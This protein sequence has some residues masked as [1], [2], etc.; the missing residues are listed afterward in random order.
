MRNL[1][2]KKFRTSLR[3]WVEDEVCSTETHSNALKIVL[4]ST[5]FFS[6]VDIY[7]DSYWDFSKLLLRRQKKGFYSI[8]VASN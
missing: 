2:L 6:P 7:I 4:F 5:I 3:V 1:D 8:I